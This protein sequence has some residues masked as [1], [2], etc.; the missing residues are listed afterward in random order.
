MDDLGMDLRGAIIYL[1]S[2][3]AS[4]R[5]TPHPFAPSAQVVGAN[6]ST[7]KITEYTFNFIAQDYQI[8]GLKLKIVLPSGM[9]FTQNQPRVDVLSG[10]TSS[11]NISVSN[12]NQLVIEGGFD[13][14]PAVS[15]SNI[16]FTVDY[17][18][19]PYE[20]ST[21]PKV[22]RVYI[23]E[24]TS[25]EP[26]F[27]DNSE[28][29]VIINTISEFSSFQVTPADY[30]TN[31]ETFYFIRFQLGDGSFYRNDY[32]K[33]TYPSD[34][35][36]CRT[37]TTNIIEQGNCS[38]F[39]G[40]QYK[41]E[42]KSQRMFG[43]R[44]YQCSSSNGT[45]IELS[46]LCC[47]PETTKPTGNFGIQIQS[48]NETEGSIYY[49]SMGSPVQMTK[50]TFQD[51]NYTMLNTWLGYSN[52]FSF[53]IKKISPYDSSDIDQ[54]S[55]IIP[56][57]LSIVSCPN[58]IY[59]ERGMTPTAGGFEITC[60]AQIV[61]I[62]SIA[63]LSQIFEF[64]LNN[65]QN[66]SLAISPISF[67]VETSNSEGFDGESGISDDQY[68]I[69]AYPC[70]TCTP[71][72]TTNCTDCYSQD[73]PVF[74]GGISLHVH[75]ISESLGICLNT[76]PPRT[77]QYS[78]GASCADCHTTCEECSITAT[79]CT[80]C[81]GSFLHNYEC[82]LFCP[83]GYSDNV[84]EWTC[85]EIKSFEAGSSIQVLGGEVEI[86]TNY[87][88]KL[89]PE[90]RLKFT[91]SKLEITS[92]PSIDVGNSCESTLGICSISGSLITLTNILT[93]DYDYIAGGAPIIAIIYN[94]YINPRVSYLLSETLFSIKTK[95]N[96]TIYHSIILTV[97]DPMITRYIPHILGGTNPLSF[98]SSTT[99]TL[100][101]LSFNISNIEYP[102]PIGHK[103]IFTFPNSDIWLFNSGLNLPTYTP[104]ESLNIGT[105]TIITPS[106]III[107]G[108]FTTGVVPPDSDIRFSIN[109]I[110]NPYALGVTNNIILDIT[111]GTV[112]EK[113]FTLTTGLM[114][115]IINI[116]EYS[117]F[118]V[119]PNNYITSA[120][121]TY[122]FSITLGD[123]GMGIG[124]QIYIKIPS[125]VTDC[126]CNTIIAT[127]GFSSPIINPNYESNSDKYYFNMPCDVPG[128]TELKFEM[129]CNNPE[130]T[131]DTDDFLIQSAIIATEDIFYEISG[132]SVIM[133]ILNTFDSVAITI[134]DNRPLVNNT[135]TLT[136]TRTA[137]YP[138]T[139]I[140]RIV[141][142]FPNSM[143]ISSA[144]YR[145]G[146]G[147]SGTIKFNRE[148]HE[149]IIRGITQLLHIFTLDLL[150]IQNP[151]LSADDIQLMVMTSN[152]VGG[153]Q[154]ERTYTNILHT[155]CDFPCQTCEISNVINCESCFP[156]LD[157]AHPIDTPQAYFLVPNLKQ[158]LDECPLTYYENETAVCDLCD[159]SSCKH[160]DISSTNC[161]SCYPEKFLHM[162][163]CI[164][165]CLP[166]YYQNDIDWL[167]ERMIYIYIYI[168][169]SMP[170][171]MC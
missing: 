40:N 145:L 27:R 86:L 50:G 56:S 123:G 142:L 74:E 166:H 111:N 161:T 129:D 38:T 97:S 20:I 19:N 81:L 21:S 77:Y 12:N 22:F 13:G 147:I 37:N 143:N 117:A 8:Y 62:N 52:A 156:E 4:T 135:I 101:T 87:T 36:D 30:R 113:Q 136:V 98:T 65:I 109:N 3:S 128:E 83:A 2:E 160:C 91:D 116:A 132:S 33:F 118:S 53:Y 71:S 54:V 34:I 115:D 73:N 93:A 14:M 158:C 122:K 75:Y 67:T 163:S 55:I 169:S 85:I 140:D 114:V 154:G 103:I 44:S 46:V 47:S 80:K 66:P 126:D 170:C 26:Y 130:T 31:I 16:Q 162:N 151:P 164:A 68:A 141:I 70:Y 11:F 35:R 32:I 17:I 168:K 88:F 152:S 124:D 90:E 92:P 6:S 106:T 134:S 29:S 144:D 104:M 69:C 125:T 146:S 1:Y 23:Y 119:T 95:I 28:F 89:Y 155:I 150:F 94:T 149:I 148:I 15:S 159:P 61:I 133:N 84:D 120:P 7:I 9:I 59:L 5:Y 112:D 39:I 121:S 153:F 96:A 102:I 137:N 82:L 64:T 76:C 58:I 49:Y 18:Q 10:F 45:I 127:Q 165:P 24:D 60:S 43:Y 79:N 57:Q 42:S 100:S 63:S 108:I 167:C 41:F 131:H 25:D 78:S 99:V 110:L 171:N 105:L 157:P 138:S 48:D 107:E 51:F 139:H 72:L